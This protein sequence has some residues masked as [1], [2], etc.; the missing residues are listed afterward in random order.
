[1]T[2]WKWWYVGIAC[3]FVLTGLTGALL[4]SRAPD[5]GLTQVHS[6]EDLQSRT[7]RLEWAQGDPVDGAPDADLSL[8]S[9]ID[10]EPQFIEQATQ[11]DFAVL[12]TATGKLQ[13]TRDTLGQEIRVESIVKGN[14]GTAPGQTCYVW[15]GYGLQ[16]MGGEIVYRNILN[17]MQPG[18]TYLVFL[19]DNQLNDL[20][21][22]KAY[23]LAAD[24]FAYLSVPFQAFTA[25]PTDNR[26]A[27]YSQWAPYGAFLSTQQIAAQWNH[28]AQE[29][30]EAY[31]LA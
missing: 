30:L 26:T 2:G 28:I 4:L 9:L 29:I 13:V 17:L 11:A 22:R 6:V 25:L 1:M 31:H 12:A 23:Y 3:L 19:Q 16:V 7:V 27:P 14:P 15:N 8:K 5:A 21:S 24:N 18:K 10:N 20:R